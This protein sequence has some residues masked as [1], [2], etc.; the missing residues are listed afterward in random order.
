MVIQ[1]VSSFVRKL[2]SLC[3]LRCRTIYLLKI[4]QLFLHSGETKAW[5]IPKIIWPRKDPQ[6]TSCCSGTFRKS[7]NR[8][9]EVI[10][11]EKLRISFSFQ[12]FRNDFALTTKTFHGS[13]PQGCLLAV[14]PL[15]NLVYSRILLCF[16]SLLSFFSPSIFPQFQFKSGIS[17][18]PSAL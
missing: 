5:F 12:G 14:F 18:F 17:G 3:Y 1:M 6:I 16:L 7:T 4:G 9:V 11:R 15:A 8:D 10:E 2:L 13:L